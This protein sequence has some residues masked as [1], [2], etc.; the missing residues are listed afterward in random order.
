MLLE[1]RVPLPYCVEDPNVGYLYMC[2]Q[3]NLAA[4]GG[5]EGV[6]WI[7]NDP[8]SLLFSFSFTSYYNTDGHIQLD[9]AGYSVPKNKGQYSLKQ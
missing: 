9:I 8:F 1:F 2:M 7:K 5:G 4:T 3:A 6:D